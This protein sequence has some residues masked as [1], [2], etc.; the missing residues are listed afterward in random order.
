MPE[1]VASKNPEAT[2]IKFAKKNNL[3]AAQ[4]EK[5]GHAFN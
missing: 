5:L 4:L 2:L 1:V 3:Y